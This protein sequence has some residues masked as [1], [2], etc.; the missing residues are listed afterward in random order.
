M[1]GTLI[2]PTGELEG[3]QDAEGLGEVEEGIV[4]TGELE[5]RQ[6][7]RER[8]SPTTFIVPTGELEGRQGSSGFPVAPA[9]ESDN[10]PCAQKR[11][12]LEGE[13]ER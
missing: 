6:D 10:P 11:L 2:V 13:I 5:G 3:R 12:P 4:P 1:T 7:R 9:A 8:T